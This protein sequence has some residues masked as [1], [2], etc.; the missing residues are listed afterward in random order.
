MSDLEMENFEPQI[1]KTVDE[2][3][4]EHSFELI[5]VVTIDEQDYGLLIYMEENEDSEEKEGEEEEQEVIVMKILKED[6]KFT[7][8]SIENEDEFNKVIQAVSE[9]TDYDVQ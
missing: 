6:E 2:E 9:Q 1:I 4:V 3:G 8:E 5:D 7:F